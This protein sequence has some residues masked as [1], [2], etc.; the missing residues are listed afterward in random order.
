MARLPGSGIRPLSE[1]RQPKEV[2]KSDLVVTK[3]GAY[4]RDN[5]RLSQSYGPKDISELGQIFKFQ[6]PLFTTERE[7]KILV[8]NEDKSW[9]SEIAMTEDMSKIFAEK[10][11]KFYMMCIPDKKNQLVLLHFVGDQEW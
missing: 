2:G 1:L 4:R 11:P 5:I 10:G 9:T 3:Y 7:P 6:A 8:Y